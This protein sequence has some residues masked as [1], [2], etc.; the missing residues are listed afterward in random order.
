MFI[1]IAPDTWVNRDLIT[2]VDTHTSPA[3]GARFV[4]VHF[5]GDQTLRLPGTVAL[6]DTLHRINWEHYE[7]EH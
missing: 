3:T 4:N 6:H 5:A 1:E 2:F 7:R